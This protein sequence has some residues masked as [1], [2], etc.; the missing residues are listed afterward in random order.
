MWKPRSLNVVLL[1]QGVDGKDGEPGSAGDKGD[2]VRLIDFKLACIV[3]VQSV[4]VVLL[5]SQ[6]IKS[7]HEPTVVCIIVIFLLCVAASRFSAVS[8][9]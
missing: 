7:I 9:L 6:T 3:G 5:F 8:P 1:L 4:R 2:K